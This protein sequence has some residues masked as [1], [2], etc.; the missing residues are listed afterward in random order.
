MKVTVCELRNEP[1]YLEQ[2]WQELAAHV[3]SESSDLV[4]LPEMPFYP[5][6]ARG[7][8]VDDDVW[9]AS[10]EAHDRWITRLTELESTLVI[11]TRP[12]VQKQKKFNEGFIWDSTN[13]Y[14]GVHRKY[15]LPDDEGWW[16]ASWYDRGDGV[17]SVIQSQKGTIGFLICTE[18]WFNVHAREY[19]K[20]GIELLVTPR[21]TEITS[22]DK[23]LAGGRAAAVVSGAY[24][25]SSNYSY[26][27]KG[28][29]EWGGGG[30]IIEPEE[31]H[32]LGLT[33]REHPFLT[34]EIDLSV[35]Q[36]AKLSYP[37]N[38]VG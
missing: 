9:K 13:G 33:S 3:K 5:W 10:V 8:Q 2:D 7:N 11:S 15:Y 37:R 19:A 6:I 23:W 26:G 22:I 4:L 35:A 21:A 32:V 1:E 24:S 14:Q 31:G 17:F 25:L 30:W 36:N 27:K 34:L 38:V 12:V 20:E 18:L 29:I 16:E 28:N